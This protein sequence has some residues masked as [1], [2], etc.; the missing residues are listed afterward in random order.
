MM[1]IIRSAAEAA[2]AVAA[3]G[4][5]SESGAEGGGRLTKE[6]ASELA[7]LLETCRPLILTHLMPCMG[8]GTGFGTLDDKLH[9][10]LFACHLECGDWDKVQT[11]CNSVVSLTT[12]WGTESGLAG[13]PRV[14]FDQ[15]FPFWSSAPFF[16]EELEAAAEDAY[17]DEDMAVAGLNIVEG[18]PPGTL[19]KRPG[20]EVEQGCR[21]TVEYPPMGPH[22]GHWRERS[23]II[24]RLSG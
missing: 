10:W 9:A 17:F 19:R 4:S 24:S 22:P 15:H 8:L 20:Q 6:Q 12:D 23:G 14:D 5:D 7:S 13:V 11:F 3:A 1:E 21:N 18:E 2:E 16:D